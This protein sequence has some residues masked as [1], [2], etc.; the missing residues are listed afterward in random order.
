M[1]AVPVEPAPTPLEV[2]AIAGIADPVLRN[3]RITQCYHELARAFAGGTGE[4]ANW[5]SFATWASRQAGQSIRQ[6]DLQRALAQ[7]LDA[8][9]GGGAVQ[10][11]AAALRALGAGHDVARV[12]RV[13]RH[14]LGLD[15]IAARTAAA[16]A[17]GNR[18]VFAEIGREF[19]R[20]LEH[21]G[22][23][24]EEAADRLA[25]FTASLRP[26]EPPEGQDLLQRAFRHYYQARFVTDPAAR[27]QLLFLANLEVGLHEQTRL[28]PE[29]AEAVDAAVLEAK[30][31]T[32]KLLAELLPRRGAGVRTRRFFSRLLGG[33]TPFDRAVEALLAEARLRVRRVITEHLMTLELGGGARLRLGR[34]LE[35]AFPVSL[36]APS[37]PEL[38][39]LLA[40]IDPT[41]EGTARS[42]ASDWAD[43]AERMHYIADLFRC[44]HEAPELFL[45]PFTPEQVSAIRAGA[46]PS[47]GL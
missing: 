5:C 27:A 36:A 41:P 1:S 33:R 30:A 26:G 21:C 2:D 13:V 44:C 46:V 14:A 40:R 32:P 16:V 29:I 43:L 18:K 37:D 31:L 12:R 7:A 17:R 22:R 39:A 23:D 3:L 6:Q 11:V 8:W 20:F 47:A 38:R 9:L 45:P 35:R 34:D 24:E 42:G 10:T 19:A 25:A 4:V 28:Q 15:V